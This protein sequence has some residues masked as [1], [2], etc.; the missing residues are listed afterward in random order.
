M[1]VWHIR[2]ECRKSAECGTGSS[3]ENTSGRNELSGVLLYC[4]TAVKMNFVFW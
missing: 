1:T 3:T 2:D 4:D